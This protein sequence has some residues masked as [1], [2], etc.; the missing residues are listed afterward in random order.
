MSAVDV[1]MARLTTEEGERMLPYDDATAKNVKAPVGNLSWG[2]G[3]NL[4]QC[5]SP[6]LFEAMERYLL[7]ALDAQLQ[8]YSWY[9]TAGDVR[10]SVFLD[11]AYNAGLHGLLGYPHMLAAAAIGEWSV[12][13]ANCTDISPTLDASRYA[14]LRALLLSG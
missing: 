14:P 3:F 10:A 5:G 4:M 7:G 11:I 1:L 6:G 13:A 2:R 8:S 9:T 12:A